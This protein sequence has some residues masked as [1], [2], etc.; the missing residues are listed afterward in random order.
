MASRRT[1][2]KQE[3]WQRAPKGDVHKSVFDYV[4]EVERVQFDEFNRFEQMAALYDPPTSSSDDDGRK[5]GAQ[6]T[7]N[8]IASNVDTVTSVIAATEVRP[9]FLTDDGDWSTQRTARHLSWYAEGLGKKLGV[10][11]ACAKGFKAGALKGTGLNK[12]YVD[13]FGAIRVEPTLVDDIV[14]DESEQRFGDPRQLHHRRIVGVDSLI[15]SFPDYADEIERAASSGH[16]AQKWAGYRP[17]ERD[18]LVCLES[19]Y[20]PF[21]T[22]P[23]HENYRPGRWTITID[24]FDLQDEEWH[25]PFFPFAVF[26]WTEKTTGWYGI[27][28]AWRIAGH[29]RTLN[30]RN[31]QIDRQHD[32]LAVPTTYVRMA[33]ANLSVK[34]RGPQ[35]TVVVYKDEIPKTIIPPA[36]SG[37]TYQSRSDLKTSAFEEF[38]Q[39]RMAAQSSKPTGL[40]SGVA[41]REYRDQTTQRFATQ[42]K[43]FEQFFLDTLYLVIDCA[44]DLGSDAPTIVRKS[45]HG[46]KKIP[47]RK[48]DMGEVKVQ[49]V[50]AS[51]L[52]RTPAG[53]LQ[54]TMEAAQAGI[55]SQESARRMMMP[56]SPLDLEQELSLYNAAVECLERSFEAILDGEE[57]VVPEPYMN[58]KLAV[59]RG[60]ATLLNAEDDG[61]P[62]DILEGMRQFVVQ[63]A[64]LQA[65]ASGAG[66]Q[67]TMPLP[68][69][70]AP[71]VDP[72]APAMPVDPAAAAMA[73]GPPVGPPDMG[74]TLT[75]AGVGPANFIQ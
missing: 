2:T 56:H 15:A 52:S 67:P 74:P 68:S 4:A 17:I 9:R 21:G 66:Q 34:T 61:A 32:Q 45:R 73:A 47:W 69:D 50:A 48:V 30:K 39:S 13:A 29:Q 11:Q 43:G 28:G 31:W 54:M 46:P 12:V 14:V 1:A 18:E 38:G 36:V 5:S 65:K 75:G 63:A 44:K 20:L 51:N 26:R 64:W 59:W 16:G 19:W 35:G 3:A 23:E 8:V 42:E 24:S 55:I 60:Q 33:D 49:L 27:G 7:E 70:A 6:M 58:L 71:A 37:E 57:G 53:R 41:L 62:E 22:D 72:M 10:H 40:D 25:K